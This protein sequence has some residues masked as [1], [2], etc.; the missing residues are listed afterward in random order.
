MGVNLLD[1]VMAVLDIGNQNCL[2][3][4]GAGDLFLSE[5]TCWRCRHGR[6]R[7]VDYTCEPCFAYLTEETDVDPRSNYR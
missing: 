6:P 3:S 2:A 5:G 7:A 4:P 1:R